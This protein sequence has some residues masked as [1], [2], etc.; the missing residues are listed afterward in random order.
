VIQQLA[1]ADQYELPLQDQVSDVMGKLNEKLTSAFHATK[2]SERS[3]SPSGSTFFPLRSQ[4]QSGQPRT[5]HHAAAKVTLE[6][7][8][9]L[10]P[11]DELGQVLNKYGSVAS[12]M[13]AFREEMNDALVSKFI[14]PL[15]NIL[16][17]VF[18]QAASARRSA[19]KARLD[20][21]ALKT[22]LKNLMS[23]SSSP[24]SPDRMNSLQGELEQAEQIFAV[25]VEDA[26]SRMKAVAENPLVIQCISDLVEAQRNFHK[27]S[28]ELLNGLFTI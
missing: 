3:E 12:K 27:K 18:G 4:S 20:L 2:S 21:D 26:L 5:I 15:S 16:D 7:A 14:H 28:F 24:V 1:T 22:K 10:P 23:D 19:Q 6:G 11:S 25:S 8:S 13:G 17:V 9:F